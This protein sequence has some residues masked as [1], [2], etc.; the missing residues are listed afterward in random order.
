MTRNIVMALAS[1]CLAA[2]IG[3]ADNASD[4]Q[5]SKTPTK[6]IPFKVIHHQNLLASLI[7]SI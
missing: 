4:E 1:T 7:P 3:L 6:K 2:T 5:T